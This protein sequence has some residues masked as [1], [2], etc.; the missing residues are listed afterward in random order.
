MDSKYSNALILIIQGEQE[1]ELDIIGL[2][3]NNRNLQVI[4]NFYFILLIFFR[5]MTIHQA[6]KYFQ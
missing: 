1:N 4:C 2:Y 6:E 3:G 5:H